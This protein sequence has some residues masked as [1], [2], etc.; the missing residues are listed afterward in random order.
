MAM[1][2]VFADATEWF[3]RSADCYRASWDGAPPDSWG[4]PIGALKAAVLAGDVTAG[5]D[6]ATWAAS[7]MPEEPP[8]PIAAFA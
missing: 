3:L 4:R 7:L 6:T 8:S 2:G 5:V 1:Q